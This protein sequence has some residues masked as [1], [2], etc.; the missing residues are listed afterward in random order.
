MEG[1]AMTLDEKIAQAQRH[2]DSGR[3]IIE[4]QRAMVARH[5]TPASIDLLQLFEQTQQIFEL[6][7]AELLKRQ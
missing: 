6:D 4:R 2:V 7:L 5:E 3:M 1:T